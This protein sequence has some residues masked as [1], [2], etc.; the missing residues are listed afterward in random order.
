MKP[1]CNYAG[2]RGIAPGIEDLDCVTQSADLCLEIIHRV[3]SPYAGI[4]LDI[5]HFNVTRE[6]RLLLGQSLP[7]LRNART[8]FDDAH[9]LIW[10][11]K[12]KARF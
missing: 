6:R 10:I 11:A 1:A 7:S 3:D 9:R 2:K 12:G 5:T 4:N 8:H